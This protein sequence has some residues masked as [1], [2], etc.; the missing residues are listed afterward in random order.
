MP[1]PWAVF[2]DSNMLLGCIKGVAE[3]TGEK[4]KEPVE[5][6]TQQDARSDDRNYA[7]V[8]T[9]GKCS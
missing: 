4:V 1:L 6:G 9:K 5:V 7:G 8:V 3:I 2:P